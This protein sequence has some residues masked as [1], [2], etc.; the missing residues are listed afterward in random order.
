MEELDVEPVLPPERYRLTNQGADGDRIAEGAKLIKGAK[1]PILLVGHAVHT[2]KSG[3]KVKE[4]ALK[5]NCPV[6][7]TSGGTSFI[8]GP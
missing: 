8:E 1:N 3:E 4:L 5:M 7:Q 6:I 2:T